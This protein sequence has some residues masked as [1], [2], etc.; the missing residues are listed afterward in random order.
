M[1]G[2]S[3]S[4]ADVLAQYGEA[5]LAAQELEEAM[6]GLIGVRAELAVAA[7]EPFDMEE[8]S[9]AQ[10][11]WEHLFALPAGRLGKLLALEGEV[12][13]EV[14]RAVC[15]RNMLAHHYLRDRASQLEGQPA[16]RDQMAAILA[17]SAERFRALADRLDAERLS[18][19]AE[20][21]LTED[22]ITLPHE[23]RQNRY[24]NPNTDDYEPPEPWDPR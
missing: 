12:G 23:A 1:E 17:G 15:A 8:F 19:M 2:Q 13:G 3:P 5:L 7:S 6:V 21:G 20:H 11:A 16:E 22:H 10:E 24:W 14:E 9:R 18:A 4:R